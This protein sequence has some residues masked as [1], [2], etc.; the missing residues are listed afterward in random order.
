MQSRERGRREACGAAPW[1]P[2]SPCRPSRH[3]SHSAFCILHSQFNRGF[4][5]IECLVALVILAIGLVGVFSL[6]VA[7]VATHKKGIDQ[8]TAGTLGQKVIAD[9]QAN[10]DDDYLKGLGDLA[11]RNNPQAPRSPKRRIE[12]KDLTDPDF[13]DLYKYDL[14]LTPL[15]S[16]RREA[17]AVVLRV[18]WREGGE[19]QAAVFETV[20]LRKLER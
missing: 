16:Q 10:L 8:T 20:V 1:R 7:G 18:K 17:Y 3:P 6:F 14:V 4:T 19:E 2:G 12:L 15:E 9:L 13:P 11:A 5:L